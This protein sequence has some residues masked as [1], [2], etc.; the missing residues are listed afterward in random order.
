ME[1][2]VALCNAL[3]LINSVTYWKKWVIIGTGEALQLF[4]VCSKMQRSHW[5]CLPGETP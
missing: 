2:G 3:G 1:I 5:V 4:A